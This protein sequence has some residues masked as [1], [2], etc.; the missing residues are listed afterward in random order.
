VTMQET[1]TSIELVLDGQPI[2][3]SARGSVAGALLEAGVA[4][5]RSS[6]RTHGPR[7]AFC[8]MG[9][10]QECAI[11]IDGRLQQACLV[12]PR[13]GMTIERGGAP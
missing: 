12:T 8:F 13:A 9:V 6:P 11:L 3:V 1:D 4:W 7:G 10:C 5:L 2:R